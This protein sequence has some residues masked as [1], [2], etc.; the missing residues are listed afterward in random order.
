MLIITLTLLTAITGAV[1]PAQVDAASKKVLECVGGEPRN[2]KC[3][4]AI[5]LRAYSEDGEVNKLMLYHWTIMNSAQTWRGSAEKQGADWT[6][7]GDNR[8]RGSVELEIDTTTRSQFT[9]KRPE[10][11]PKTYLNL[12]G[13][14]AVVNYTAVFKPFHAP[15]RSET[16]ENLSL[17]CRFL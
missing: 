12:K 15:R 4:G 10:C 16:A 2:E 3:D 9:T 7:S 13:H 1:L 6:F 8:D 11:F 17:V 5:R 14:E